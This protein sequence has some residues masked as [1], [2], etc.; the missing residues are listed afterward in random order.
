M[1]ILYTYEHYYH[2]T[3]CMY[4]YIVYYIY[5]PRAS[6]CELFKFF[7]TAH[8]YEFK[9]YPFTEINDS[10]SSLSAFFLPL[11]SSVTPLGRVLWSKKK[12]ENC[13]SLFIRTY[14]HITTEFRLQFADSNFLKDFANDASFLAQ[15]REIEFLTLPYM[16]I[17]CVYVC[18]CL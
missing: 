10:S 17:H 3:V 8:M 16:Y 11:F 18:V 14:M 2:A 9:F 4:V 1:F 5:E 7:T 12:N 6:L 15:K 13:D